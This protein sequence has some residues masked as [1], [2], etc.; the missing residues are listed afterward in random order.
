M[1]LVDFLLMVVVLLPFATLSLGLQSGR[2]LVPKPV[3]TH[4]AV[5][6]YLHSYQH[7]LF[8]SNIGFKHSLLTAG[9]TSIA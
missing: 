8:E 2:L 6:L 5:I 3:L 7:Q 1:F 9:L 4:P